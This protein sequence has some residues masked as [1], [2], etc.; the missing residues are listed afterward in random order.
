MLAAMENKLSDASELL[1]RQIHP[2][3]LQDGEPSSDRFRPSELDQNLMSVDRSALTTAEASHSLY[4]AGGKKSA[5]VFG[6]TV[7]E[8]GSESIEC[9]SDPIKAGGDQPE[10][11]AHAVADYSK[12][13]TSQQKVIAKKLKRL[14][15]ERGALHIS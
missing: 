3:F 10:N 13:S 7:G 11:P 4:T 6:L 8:F 9:L 14:A 2:K 12:Y 15:V 1:F 5:A